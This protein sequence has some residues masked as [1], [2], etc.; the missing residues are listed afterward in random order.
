MVFG[1]FDLWIFGDNKGSK[2]RRLYGVTAVVEVAD[3][4]EFWH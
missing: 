4:I 2:G 3:G 1:G